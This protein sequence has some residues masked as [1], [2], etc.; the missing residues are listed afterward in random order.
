[1]PSKNTPPIKRILKIW[2]KFRKKKSQI[3]KWGNSSL[4]DKPYVK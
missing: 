1:M 4:P 3:S 2:R